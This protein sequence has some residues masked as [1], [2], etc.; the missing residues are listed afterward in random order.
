MRRAGIVG[1]T[2]GG[3]TQLMLSWTFGAGVLTGI[4]A[5]LAALG[6]WRARARLAMRVPLRHPALL[7]AAG[8]ALF[9]VAAA[10]LYFGLKT[11]RGVTALAPASAPGAMAAATP[12]QQ[13]V[14]GLESQLATG[15][16]SPDDWELL[17]K[18]YDFLGRPEDAGRA[19]A[20][21]LGGGA[22]PVTAMSVAALDGLASA[23]DSAGREG[24]AARPPEAAP[25][26]GATLGQL[27]QRVRDRPGDAAGW[28]ALAEA[29]R[30][31]RD[32]RGARDA[33][34]RVVALHGMT[35]QSWADY[36]D[37]LASLGGNSLGGAAGHAI[38]EALALDP[39]NLK[40]LW[41]KASQA[42]Q[43]R[44]YSEALNLWH[45]LRSELPGDSPD[46]RIIDGNIAEDTELGGSVPEP[47]APAA[48]GAGVSGTVSLD[49]RLA[50]Q[51]VPG[52]TLF[53]YARAAD[54]PGPP[55]A[56]VRAAAGSWPVQFRLDDTMAM[57]PSRRLS[58]FDRVVIEARIS[59]S[60]QATPSS[61]DLYVTSP[62]VNPGAAAR[63]ALV[64][65]RRL[66]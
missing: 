66:D 49:S 53:I 63:L 30:N 46:A 40:A 58:Q 17:A 60:G 12:M 33:L 54:S 13:A 4:L 48:A 15:G 3:G 21:I 20:H 42:H 2:A 1:S 52:A 57:L 44:R 6:A 64:I 19:R 50:A 37:V 23:L 25:P 11:H 59:R 39:H 14:A 43:Q 38:D 35:A 26:T 10:V 24:P 28:L 51:V 41:L 62:V 5:S 16:G 56:V 9:A 36:A 61:G 47:A 65:D 27:R 34:A 8:V 32:E 55:L 18:A 22:A 45:R 29:Y 7:A 31:T